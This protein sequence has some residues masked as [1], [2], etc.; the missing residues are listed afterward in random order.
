ME[1]A[2]PPV[3]AL[4]QLSTGKWLLIGLGGP[5]GGWWRLVIKEPLRIYSIS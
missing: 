1:A 2:L 4:R 5:W 3:L